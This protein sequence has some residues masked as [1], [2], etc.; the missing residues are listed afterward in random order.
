VAN[1]AAQKPRSMAQLTHSALAAGA[2]P[3]Q[4]QPKAERAAAILMIDRMFILQSP[5][6][7]LSPAS[8]LLKVALGKF[9]AIALTEEAD[10]KQLPKAK[11]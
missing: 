11:L 9:G 1:G 5:C 7:M 4:K 8:T 10:T 6:L 2:E 3:I